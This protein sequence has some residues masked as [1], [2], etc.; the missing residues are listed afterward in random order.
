MVKSEDPET[1]Y[2]PK[3]AESIVNQCKQQAPWQEN[4]KIKLEL[5]I[6]VLSSNDLK[7][8][9]LALALLVYFLEEEMNDDVCEANKLKAQQ[10][11]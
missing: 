2:D 9:E 7:L 3:E 8:V 5:S 1:L 11:P 6:K 4:D 10:K